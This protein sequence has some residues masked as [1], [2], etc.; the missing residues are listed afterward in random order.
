MQRSYGIICFGLTDHNE[1]CVLVVRKRHTCQFIK[2]LMGNYNSATKDLGA[3]LRGMTVEEQL[4][5]MYCSFDVL[6]NKIFGSAK[7]GKKYLIAKA[8]YKRK[9]SSHKKSFLNRL[10]NA[11]HF[12]DQP[13]ELPKGHINDGETPIEASI[14]EFEEETGLNIGLVNLDKD[15]FVNGE[16]QSRLTYVM[17]FFV[18]TYKTRVKPG[19]SRM[20]NCKHKREIDGVEWIRLSELNNHNI[21]NIYISHIHGAEELWKWRDRRQ[22][23]SYDDKVISSSKKDFIRGNRG[24]RNTVRPQRSIK[25]SEKEANEKRDVIGIERK[26]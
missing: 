15:L 3:I 4:D 11:S 24:N 8:N 18:G 13:R 12:S 21:D 17:T 26:I 7:R 6:W 9:F 20:R 25:I 23:R 22:S 2:F 16:H 5:I 19:L 14:R 10:I 1:P